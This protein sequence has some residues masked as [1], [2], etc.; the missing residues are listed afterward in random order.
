LAELEVRAN[1]VA[2][3]EHGWDAAVVATIPFGMSTLE[4]HARMLEASPAPGKK[5]F[6]RC[7]ITAPAGPCREFFPLFRR[8]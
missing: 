2:N 8:P 1:Q 5:T 6:S 4:Q 3:C 7:A